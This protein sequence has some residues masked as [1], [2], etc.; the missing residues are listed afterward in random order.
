ML[1]PLDSWSSVGTW[2][3]FPTGTYRG[4]VGGVQVQKHED[5]LDRYKE[6]IEISQP[7]LVIE[8]G[9]RDGGSALWFR[10]QGL[11]V[12]SVDIVKPNMQKLP[13]FDRFN[14]YPGIEFIAGSSISDWVFEILLK[15]VRGKRVMVSLDSDHHSPHVQAEIGRLG[16]LVTPG[17]YLVVEDACFE[18]WAREGKPDQA[19]VGGSQ[20]P[21]RGGPLDAIEK[22]LENQATFWRD[23]ELEGLT[24]ISHSPCGWWRR[25]DEGWKP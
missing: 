3:T 18:V 4:E 23:T 10:E 11:Q 17:C 21:E 6:L 22:G 5:D 24:P 13:G 7:D 16:A 25:E 15:H 12:V 8:T 9:S 14:K 20:I 1:T 19:R 2:A